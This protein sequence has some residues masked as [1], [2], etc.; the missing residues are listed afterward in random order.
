[1][2]E[3][4]L[5]RMPRQLDDVQKLAGA[6][7]VPMEWLLFGHVFGR[8]GGPLAIGRGGD[9]VEAPADLV[10]YPGHWSTLSGQ[11]GSR[12]L[13][14]DCH[15]PFPRSDDASFGTWAG[16]GAGTYLLE[17]RKQLQAIEGVPDADGK[18]MVDVLPR[19]HDGRRLAGRIVG[20]VCG[21]D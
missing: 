11:A 6:L 2:L 21:N 20:R 16:A 8:K 9:M 13:L 19:V 1:M 17:A 12:T 18:L 4:G 3:T 15:L 7:G 14:V 5:K 10:V